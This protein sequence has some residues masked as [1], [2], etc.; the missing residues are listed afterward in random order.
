MHDGCFVA[1]VKQL[2]HGRAMRTRGAECI[3]RRLIFPSR[4]GPKSVS[5]LSEHLTGYK[6]GRALGLAYRLQGSPDELREIR[7]RLNSE[8]G[9][10][11]KWHLVPSFAIRAQSFAKRLGC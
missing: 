10:G 2:W 11:N 6:A 3:H 5:C 1:P 4:Q 8:T 7:Q 9:D